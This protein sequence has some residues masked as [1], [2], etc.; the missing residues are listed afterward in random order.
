M[1]TFQCDLCGTEFEAAKKKRFCCREH[2]SK[3]FVNLY[4]PA[5]GPKEFNGIVIVKAPKLGWVRN[6]EYILPTNVDFFQAKI[7]VGSDGTIKKT[8]LRMIR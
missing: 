5:P 6:T 1:P 3:A 4:V 7:N 8:A 2:Q